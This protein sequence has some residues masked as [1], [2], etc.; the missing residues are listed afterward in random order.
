[1]SRK[2][3]GGKQVRAVA[4]ALTTIIRGLHDDME[5]LAADNARL[6][7]RV[8]ARAEALARIED[9]A[10]R[11]GWA[12]ESDDDLPRFLAVLGAERQ[13]YADVRALCAA[14][15]AELVAIDAELHLSGAGCTRFEGDRVV[16]IRVAAVKAATPRI[17]SD[18]G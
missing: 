8:S 10:R 11:A 5:V 17:N 7:C 14:Q 6:R 1:M 3:K 9:A 2:S 4:A 18:R 16:G 12:G 13:T 15:A